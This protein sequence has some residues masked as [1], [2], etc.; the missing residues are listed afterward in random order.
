MHTRFISHTDGPPN[1]LHVDDIWLSLVREAKQI[2][3]ESANAASDPEALSIYHG[4]AGFSVFSR[5]VSTFTDLGP[6]LDRVGRANLQENLQQIKQSCLP[7]VAK[8]S[9]DSARNWRPKSAGKTSYL[10]TPVG[11]ATEVL[12]DIIENPDGSSNLYTEEDISACIELLQRILRIQAQE[13]DED[14]DDGCEVLYGQAGLLYALLRLSQCIARAQALP[15]LGANL[16]SVVNKASIVKLVHT[17][18]TRGRFGAS[19]YASN[20]SSG[21]AVPSLMWSWHHKRYL[22]AAH[23]VAGILHILLMCPVNI[24]TPYIPDILQTT[25]W[26]INYQ[27]DA[28]NWPT[29]L[30]QRYS[31]SNDLVQYVRLSLHM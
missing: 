22:G 13:S 25:E 3:R 2:Y 20:V 14:E 27:D 18:I 30:K 12:I 19:H 4:P 31:Q 6:P 29:S 26:L 11:I 16:N 15:S 7:S 24:I 23:G 17:I 10:E 5:L 21:S 8:S 1:D 9:L 28:G